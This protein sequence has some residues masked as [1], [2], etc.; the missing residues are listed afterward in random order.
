MA[1]QFSILEIMAAVPIKSFGEGGEC[2][3]ELG[4]ILVNKVP[5]VDTC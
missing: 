1:V 5:A 3:A 2:L 4:G